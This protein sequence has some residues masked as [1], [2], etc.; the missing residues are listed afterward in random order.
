MHP[1]EVLRDL[2]AGAFVPAQEQHN[3]FPL[4]GRA[5]VMVEMME[6]MRTLDAVESAL[7]RAS[8][9]AAAPQKANTESVF[10]SWLKTHMAGGG[11]LDGVAILIP[12][13]PAC[14]A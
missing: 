5:R 7:R 9:G 1:H 13:L 3:P 11:E 2:R 4:T 14:G 8:E 6:L 10:A 12:A